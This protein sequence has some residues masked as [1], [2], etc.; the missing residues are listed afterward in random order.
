MNG[1]ENQV[2]QYAHAGRW[3]TMGGHG[4]RPQD[5]E[6]KVAEW[7]ERDGWP[8]WRVADASTE[9]ET[10]APSEPIHEPTEWKPEDAKDLMTLAGIQMK[11]ELDPAEKARMKEILVAHRFER[12]GDDARRLVQ[13]IQAM[14]SRK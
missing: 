12:L 10:G 9:R 2:I 3:H 6:R 5:Y 4:E 7:N 11:R 13:D 1:I 14:N 8:R